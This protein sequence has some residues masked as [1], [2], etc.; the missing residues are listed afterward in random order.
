MSIFD[1]E[2]AQPV[3]FLYINRIIDFLANHPGQK[4]SEKLLRLTALFNVDSS[5]AI[6]HSA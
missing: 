3:K 4:F 1:A 5:P 2:F 6:M